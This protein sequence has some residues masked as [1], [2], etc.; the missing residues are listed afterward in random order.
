MESVQKIAP[1]FFCIDTHDLNRKER[2]SAYL[3]IDEK[4]ALIETSASPSV[5]YII[6]GLNELQITLDDIDY[7]IVTHIHLDHAGG[8]GLFLQSCP[9]AKL[10]VHPRG[11]GHM[12][13]PTRLIASAKAVYGE[14]FQRLFDPIVPVAPERIMEARHG[15]ILSLGNHQLTFYHT[16]GHAKHHVS[17]HYSATNGM[18]VGDTTGVCYPELAD[19]AIDLI[20]PSTSPNQYDPDTM[21]QSIQLY[22]KLNVQELY[23]GHYGAYQNPTEAYRQVRYWTPLFL[24]EGEKALAS[25]GTLAQQAKLLDTRL[26]ALLHQ[27]LQRN[28]IAESHPVYQTLP[29]DTAVSAMGI[30]DY[31]QKNKPSTSK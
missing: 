15:D 5:P 24:V 6:E 23:F 26:Q 18:F 12:V 30:L 27:Y 9:K 7:V 14:E 20:I 4:I 8:A 19:E 3:L 10:V 2:T 17:M 28:G 11:A 25:P 21:E 1:N 16:E 29:F 31:L 22:E 13:D